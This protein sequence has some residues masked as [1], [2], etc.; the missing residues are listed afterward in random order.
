[1]TEVFFVRHAEPNYNNHDDRSR[2]LSEKGLRDRKLVTQFLC[3]KKIHAVFSSPFKRAIDTVSDFANLSDYA[4]EIIDDFRER[5]VGN[6]W[7]ED[8]DTFS[9]MQWSNFSY[10]LPD[11]ESL[12]EVQRRNIHALNNLL[13]S[14]RGKSIAVG[15]H[16]TAL[17]TIINYYDPSFQY[18]E[19]AEIQNLMPWI[20]QFSFDGLRCIQIQKYD[21]FKNM[22]TV[23]WS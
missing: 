16:G 23:L 5:K 17:S 15:S 10:K 2:E 18:E 19:F 12:R 22:D 8:F 21:L 3:Q 14:F 4:V 6:S 11:G 1:M 7:I 13:T 9:R 20:V